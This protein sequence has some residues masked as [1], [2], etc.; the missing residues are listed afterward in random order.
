MFRQGYGRRQ[1]PRHQHRDAA[2]LAILLLQLF[3]Q[4]QHLPYKPPATLGLIACE[5]KAGIVKW[6]SMMVCNELT[7]RTHCTVSAGAGVLEG[8]RA[9]TRAF[10]PDTVS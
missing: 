7:V 5:A 10:T 6:V 3:Q 2:Y 8:A 9:S 4:V 1:A